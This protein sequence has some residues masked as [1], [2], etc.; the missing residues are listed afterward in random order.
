MRTRPPSSAGALFSI[1]VAKMNEVFAAMANPLSAAIYSR[2]CRTKAARPHLHSPH[3]D[4]PA[5]R[6]HRRPARRGD[7][8]DDDLSLLL[9]PQPFRLAQAGLLYRPGV[10]GPAH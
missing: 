1:P 9:R 7:R 3:A 2:G 6:H 4:G 5:V 10:D 8:L